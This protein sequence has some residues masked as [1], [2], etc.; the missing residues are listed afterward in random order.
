MKTDLLYHGW[1]HSRH[2]AI[3]FRSFV[4][5]N[6]YCPKLF[7]KKNNKLFDLITEIFIFAKYSLLIIILY[8]NILLRYGYNI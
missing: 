1:L 6:G 3:P 5:L 7:F 4:W 8:Q 2:Q